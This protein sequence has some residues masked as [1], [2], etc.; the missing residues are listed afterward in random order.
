[1]LDDWLVGIICPHFTLRRTTSKASHA[2]HIEDELK[3]VSSVQ[4]AKKF[5]KAYKQGIWEY[6][7]NG[8]PEGNRPYV[9]VSQKKRTNIMFRNDALVVGKGRGMRIKPKEISF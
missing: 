2:S 1:M 3:R 9:N 4:C 6:V 7:E 5:D 8:H